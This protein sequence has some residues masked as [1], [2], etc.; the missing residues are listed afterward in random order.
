MDGYRRF[1]ALSVTVFGATLS[2]ALLLQHHFDLRLLFGRYAPLA[3]ILAGLLS[4]DMLYKLCV[5]GI[6]SSG[7][8]KKI[9]WGGMYL[10]GLWEYASFDG[11]ADFIGI[12]RIEQDAFG[13]KVVAFG[14]DENFRRRSTLNS[15]SD[16]MGTGGV[17]EIINKRW[18]LE[19]GSRVQFSRTTLVPD[20]PLRKGMFSYPAVI[21]GETVIFGGKTDGVINYDLRM[22]RRDGFRSEDDLIASMRRK[23]DGEARDGEKDAAMPRAKGSDGRGD[24]APR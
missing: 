18:D 10:E 1:E 4:Y 9:Y 24:P 23:R 13:T 19:Q 6:K 2:G 11:H 17:Y 22:W 8:L 21:R 12:W 7:F 3:L 16:L 14:L 5:T 15:V 20:K